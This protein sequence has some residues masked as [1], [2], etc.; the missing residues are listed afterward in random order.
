MISPEPM[1]GEKSYI[2][3]WLDNSRTD[4]K[5]T[6]RC[7][8]CGAKVFQYYDS[9]RIVVPGKVEDGSNPIIIQCR[10]RFEFISNIGKTVF[11]TCK[12]RYWINR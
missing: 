4:I 12:T 6:F 3:A 8:V 5:K 7:N 2:T 11:A 10:G 1:T 9:L